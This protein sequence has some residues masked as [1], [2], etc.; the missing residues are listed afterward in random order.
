VITGPYGLSQGFTE[1]GTLVNMDPLR[2]AEFSQEAVALAGGKRLRDLRERMGLTLRAV[3]DA[4]A[5][6][7]EAFGNPEFSIPPSRLSDIETKGILPSIYRVHALALIYR[8]S[9]EEIL[10]WYGVPS[11]SASPIS[12]PNAPRTHLIDKPQV[13]KEKVNLPYRLDPAFDERKTVDFGRFVQ[14]WGSVP[15]KFIEEMAQGN[16]VYGYIGSEDLTMYP[17]LPPGSFVQVDPSRNRVRKGVWRS[18]YE[19][20]IYFLETREEYLCGWC[21]IKEGRIIVQPHPM[22]PCE[23]RILRL[24]QEAEVIGQVIG[25]AIRLGDLLNFPNE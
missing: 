15:M 2:I 8:I 4:S 5:L 23:L 9:R 7:V 14:Q 10:G 24:S 13:R 19:R 3:E 17:I 1:T 6:L 20:P 16:Y 12:L 21:M 25:A 22:S 11:G 18:D